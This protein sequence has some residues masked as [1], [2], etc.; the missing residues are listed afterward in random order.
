MY[1]IKV[2][3]HTSTRVYNYSHSNRSIKRLQEYIELLLESIN[4]DTIIVN[5]NI[6]KQVNKKIT[7]KIKTLSE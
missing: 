4:D 2:Q 7:N 1:I 5:Y 3:I 6:F